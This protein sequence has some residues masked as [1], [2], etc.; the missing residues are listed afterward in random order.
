MATIE[1]VAIVN[2][3]VVFSLCTGLLVFPNN[4]VLKCVL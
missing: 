2:A 4:L 3:I 1:T